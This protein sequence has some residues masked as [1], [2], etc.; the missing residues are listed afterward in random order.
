VVRHLT[1]H[2]R[3][4]LPASVVPMSGQGVSP[5]RHAVARRWI[6]GFL[7]GL[8]VPAVVA[9]QVTP[10]AALLFRIFLRDGRTLTSYGEYARVGDRVVF[11]LPLGET[12]GNPRLHLASVPA[13]EVDWPA[14][15]RYRDALRA[16]HYAD[17]RGEQ[18]FAALSGEVARLL[19]E[20]AVSSDKASHLPLAERARQLL[21]EWPAAHYAYRA[22]E[23]RQIQALVEE[24]VT[25]L[26][27]AR[28]DNRFDLNL[29]AAVAPPPVVPLLPPPTL[30]ESIQQAL[31]AS[32]LADSASDRASLLQSAMAL[33]DE[34]KAVLPRS[35]ARNARSEASRTLEAE[36]ELTQ[37]YARMTTRALDRA[38]SAA[39]RADVRGVERV[40]A[41]VRTRDQK[42]G[43]RRPGDVQALVA[44][45]EE[46]LDATRR[47]RLA[48]DQWETKEAALVAYRDQVR[49]ALEDLWRSRPILDEIRTLSGPEVSRLERF[50]RK[51]TM[52][53]TRLR[54]LTPPPDAQ[55]VHGVTISA[56]QLA[57]SAARTRQ[58]A[59]ASA[60]IRQAWD[61]SSAAAGALMLVE[62][63]RN[64]LRRVLQ[65]PELQ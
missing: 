24:V 30:Q 15:D 28:G 49:P 59:V 4:A 17:T 5:R 50:R 29:V 41:D 25:E 34:G 38:G 23:V 19:S 61:A 37:A 18:D 2:P 48:R 20:I 43:G 63:A 13:A 57:D 53:L 3:G 12:A 27:A 58:A 51:T 62:R 45:L 21:A 10:P 32:R 16:S 33:L 9:A 54:R 7:L 31:T 60:S 26:R 8:L 46:R 64:D 65:P 40:L 35:W 47:L 55:A 39:R 11:S 22:E 6:G 14:T 52:A 56:V 36:M 44:A 42:L 1:F